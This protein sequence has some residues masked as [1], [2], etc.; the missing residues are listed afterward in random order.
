MSLC[1]AVAGLWWFYP[2]TY[3]YTDGIFYASAAM[4]ALNLLPAYP[5]DG[6][7]IAKCVICKFLKPKAVD[8]A[9]RI[10]KLTVVAA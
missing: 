3:A 5:L 2:V 6:G 1:I 10:A 4:L 9:L 7:R 8:T